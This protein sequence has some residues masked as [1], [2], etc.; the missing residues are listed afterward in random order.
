MGDQ[1]ARLSDGGD[2]AVPVPLLPIWKAD[3][4]EEP[5]C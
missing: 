4:G 1:L 3:T 5:V 2:D